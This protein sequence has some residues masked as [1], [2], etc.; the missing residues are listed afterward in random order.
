MRKISF[1]LFFVLILPLPIGH[2]I[3]EGMIPESNNV[4]EPVY[5]ISLDDLDIEIIS[6]SIQ[7]IPSS[8]NQE[9]SDSSSP[10]PLHLLIPATYMSYSSLIGN[11]SLVQ[12]GDAVQLTAGTEFE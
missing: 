8:N 3:I 9:Q 5:T 2:S 10:N 1:I 7:I 12:K 4:T 11:S 6:Q